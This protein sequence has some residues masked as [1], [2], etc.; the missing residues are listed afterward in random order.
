MGYVRMIKAGGLH[1]VSNS[2]RFVPD[3]DDI[4]NFEQ[5]T[6]EEEGGSLQ[7][8]T[9]GEAAKTLDEVVA[10]LVKNFSDSTEYFQVRSFLFLVASTATS[11][12]FLSGKKKLHMRRAEKTKAYW[13]S[14]QLLVNVFGK[15][16]HEDK[17]PHLKNFYVIVPPLTINYVE[18]MIAAKEKMNKNIY[19]GA[20]FTD[21][22][23]A[24]GKINEQ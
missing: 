17:H 23:L 22:G 9:I 4:P 1:F 20:A 12:V 3:L 24:M 15:Q 11:V 19:S 21:D 2:I 5:L 8:D 18:H 16:L 13:S 10:N 6:I 14:F 7:N